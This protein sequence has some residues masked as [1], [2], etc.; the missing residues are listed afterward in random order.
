MRH[1]RG[2]V[3]NQ[4]CVWV[5]TFTNE[6]KYEILQ[7]LDSKGNLCINK[8]IT[9]MI[10]LSYDD[11]VKI[12]IDDKLLMKSLLIYLSRE[13]HRFRREMLK[14]M[15]PYIQHLR[16]CLNRRYPRNIVCQILNFFIPS[17][18][19]IMPP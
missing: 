2:S 12:F 15:G 1:R 5:E 10:V 9:D 7:D 3:P 19:K 8:G 11:I 16:M 14:I 6:C 13:H 4:H 18:K 17:P